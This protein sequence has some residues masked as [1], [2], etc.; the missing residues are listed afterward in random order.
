MISA[1]HSR[2]K[3]LMHGVLGIKTLAT[4]FRTLTATLAGG[5]VIMAP[6][7][8]LLSTPVI[9]CIL[10][11]VINSVRLALAVSLFV[12]FRLCRLPFFVYAPIVARRG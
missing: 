2:D 8:A 4:L 6:P 12:D 11:D 10:Y 7:V 3:L 9:T 1:Y 5:L